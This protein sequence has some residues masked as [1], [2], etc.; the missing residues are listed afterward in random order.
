MMGREGREGEEV[1]VEVEGVSLL[2]NRSATFSCSHSDLL[3]AGGNFF[4]VT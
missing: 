4:S 1:E 3:V 2:L